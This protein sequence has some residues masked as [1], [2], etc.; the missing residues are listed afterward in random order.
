MASGGS[1][2]PDEIAAAFMTGLNSFTKSSFIAGLT[3]AWPICL[4]YIAIGLALGVLA[5]KAGLAPW[6]IC[7]MSLLV[8]AGSSQFI[9][10]SMLAGGA[11][12]IS[13][14]L[15]TLIV[16]LRHLLMSAALSAHV[17]KMDRRL[18]PLFAYGV[19]DESFAVNMAR[20]AKGDWDWQKSLVVNHTTNLIWIL[21][22]MLGGISGQFIPAGAFGID[23]AL[24]AMFIGL[25]LFQLR[26]R[27]YV[28]V[29]ALGG[30]TA[31][32]IY[33]YLGGFWHVFFAPLLAV[34]LGVIVKRRRLTER[35][36]A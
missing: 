18:L 29:A 34:A 15:T 21:S 9:A 14:I 12:A 2:G 28:L 30:V 13:I 4:G 32:L 24:S 16:N 36:R 31:L 5:E 6:Q 20:F 8:Y 10:V 7:L 22:T 17:K 19:T 25:L 26:G 23:F 11:P 1:S 33:L 35:E 27:E 3:A